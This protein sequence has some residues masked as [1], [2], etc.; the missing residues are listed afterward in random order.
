MPKPTT[1][2]QISVEQILELSDRV[3]TRRNWSSS[4]AILLA[5]YLVDH[6]RQANALEDIARNLFDLIGLYRHRS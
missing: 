3:A 5:E 1:D 4:E 6:K 2:D